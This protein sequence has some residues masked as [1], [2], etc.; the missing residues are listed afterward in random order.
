MHLVLIGI[1]HRTAPVELR[2]RLDF[3]T[4]GLDKALK[5]LAARGTVGEAVV[6]STCNRAE[7]YAASE[8]AEE[9]RLDL[10]QFVAEYHGVGREALAP[11]IYC[12][13]GPEV[14]RHLFRVAAGLDS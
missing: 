8:D 4:R 5:A 13:E 6:L 3:P 2:E 12:L 14:A 1:S 11:H 10:A 9:A 7:I